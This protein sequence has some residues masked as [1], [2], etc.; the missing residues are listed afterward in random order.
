MRA[1]RRDPAVLALRPWS[2]AEKTAFDV[3]QSLKNEADFDGHDMPQDLMQPQ[4]R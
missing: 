1:Y 2:E 3:D 4:T